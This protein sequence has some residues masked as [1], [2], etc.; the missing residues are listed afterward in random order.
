[1]GSE[2]L[3]IYVKHAGTVL[4]S[5]RSSPIGTGRCAAHFLD[6]GCL[7]IDFLVIGADANQQATKAMSCFRE[8][9]TQ[10]LGPKGIFVLFTPLRYGVQTADPKTPNVVTVKD[11][12]VWRTYVVKD[13]V[14]QVNPQPGEANV[15]PRT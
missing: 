3:E 6:R 8:M 2:Q 14:V 15:I 9:V 10:E 11:A 1:M 5:G 13:N 12:I 4:V 7:P